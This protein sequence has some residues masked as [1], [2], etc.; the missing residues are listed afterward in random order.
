MLG[1][2]SFGDYFKVEQVEWM[3]EF[4]TKELGL[5]PEKL[6]VTVHRGNEG[7]GIAKDSLA[8]DTWKRMFA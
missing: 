1:N 4:L 3:F 7:L 6:Y 5:N 8:V 2:W